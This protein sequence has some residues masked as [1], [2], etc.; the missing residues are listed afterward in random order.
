MADATVSW[1]LD[2]TE[3]RFGRVFLYAIPGIVGGMALLVVVQIPIY[4]VQFVLAGD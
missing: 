3:R 4:L 2:V 1:S